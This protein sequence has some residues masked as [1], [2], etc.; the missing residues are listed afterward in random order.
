MATLPLLQ[1]PE[2]SE[3]PPPYTPT[4]APLGLD[5]PMPPPCSLVVDEKCKKAGRVLLRA[6]RRFRAP[7]DCI[8][9]GE[10][11]IAELPPDKFEKAVERISRGWKKR[12][13]AIGAQNENS[14]RFAKEAAIRKDLELSRIYYQTTNIHPVFTPIGQGLVPPCQMKDLTPADG[15]TFAHIS[16]TSCEMPTDY[17]PTKKEMDDLVKSLSLRKDIFP[18]GHKRDGCYGRAMMI[19]RYLLLMGV[20]EHHLAKFYFVVPPSLAT[21]IEGDLKWRYHVAAVV[22]LSD[23][24]AA[25]L[26]PALD[27]LQVLTLKD[28]LSLQTPLVGQVLLFDRQEEPTTLY[29]DP[30]H[31]AFI[32]TAFNLYLNKWEKV[33]D[34]DEA[35]HSIAFGLD[36][37]DEASIRNDLYQ[38]GIFRSVV[39]VQHIQAALPLREPIKA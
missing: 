11:S 24:S 5:I 17:T 10:K 37:E 26:D 30:D 4:G 12:A 23:G 1:I 6:I 3:L 27:S 13:K 31:P 20:P 28:W 14:V 18:W 33:V 36:L 16:A 21:P 25:V 15:T 38:L 19:L 8:K 32:R 34:D 22:K 29:L 2:Q 7:L 9:Q 39:D 35:G